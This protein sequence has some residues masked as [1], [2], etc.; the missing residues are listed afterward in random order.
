MRNK[1]LLVCISLLMGSMVFMTSCGKSSGNIKGVDNEKVEN[2]AETRD[3]SRDIISIDEFERI[4]ED[5]G[6]DI[7]NLSVDGC[8]S[9]VLENDNIEIQF[10]TYTDESVAIKDYNYRSKKLDVSSP[11]EING[12][13]Y[14]ITYGIGI[15]SD[16]IQRYKVFVRIDNT[17]LLLIANEDQIEAADRFL[18]LIGYN[19]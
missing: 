7:H 1:I 2:N 10:N 18:N 16:D 12:K 3:D 14:N 11:K 8:K 15:S 4:A 6:Y 17:Y 9:V 19:K 5:E 13:N